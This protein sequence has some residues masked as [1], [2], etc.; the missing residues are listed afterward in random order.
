MKIIKPN[1]ISHSYTQ[2]IAAAPD[3]VFPL[4]CPVREKDWVEGWDPELVI[5]ESGFAEKDCI[6]TLDRENSKDHWIV[7]KHDS[8]NYE[9]EM[10]I[11]NPEVTVGKLEIK[12]KEGISGTT[13][14]LISYTYTSLSEKG[15]EFVNG[16]TAE[17]YI[18]FMKT[19]EDE[20]NYYLENKEII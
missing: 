15:D 19:W 16:F 8:E 1:R 9:I 20:M 12:L 3:K 7:T 4:L 10:V 11:I 6:F 14:A 17:K 2:K 18:D 5:S 13:E